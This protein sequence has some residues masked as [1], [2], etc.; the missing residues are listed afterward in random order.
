MHAILDIESNRG[1]AEDDQALKQ[2]LIETGLGSFL[3]HDDGTQLLMIAHKHHLLAS[4]DQRNH[5]LRLGRLGGLVDQHRPEFEFR[6]SW[7][8]GA[9]AGAANDIGVGQYL[10]FGGTGELLEF[11]LILAG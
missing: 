11:L 8:A 4:K 2:R 5:A 10:T 6:Q 3:V 9:D 7:I 1:A